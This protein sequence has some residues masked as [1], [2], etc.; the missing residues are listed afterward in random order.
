MKFLYI[1]K[2]TNKLTKK[3]EVTKKIW[4]RVDCQHSEK[5]F[6]THKR[7]KRTL[8]N[9][10]KQRQDANFQGNSLF[11]SYV[12]YKNKQMTYLLPVGFSQKEE[13]TRLIEKDFQKMY[14]PNLQ[15]INPPV[16]QLRCFTSSLLELYTSVLVGQNDT[17]F[18][19]TPVRKLA[20]VRS[21]R[22]LFFNFFFFF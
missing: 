7:L 19:H 10:T 2:K 6:K 4:N 9:H 22:F 12:Q 14:Q 16:K 18:N 21:C 13:G 20:C 17:Y 11:Q 15:E 8:F 5:T 3:H 1:N